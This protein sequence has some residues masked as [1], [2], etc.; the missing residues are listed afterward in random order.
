MQLIKKL[1]EKGYVKIQ[2]D[3]EDRRAIRIIATE[4]RN[5][6]TDQYAEKNMDFINEMFADLSKDEIEL[7]CSAQF[8]IYE[9]LGQ[10]FKEIK[11]YEY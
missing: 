3:K 1:Q 10:M 6:W 2:E 4:K 11:K 9:K 7:F 5:L 8:K